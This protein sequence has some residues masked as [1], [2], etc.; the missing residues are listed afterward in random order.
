MKIFWS[1]QSDTSKTTGRFLVRDAIRAAI[2]KL[3]EV[4]DVEEPVDR[5]RLDS[6]HLDQDRQGLS[7]SPDL[8]DAIFKKIDAASIVIADITIVARSKGWRD[9]NNKLV[10]GRA[11]INPNVGIEVGYAIKAVGD[12]NILLVVN[13]HYGPTE[14]LP[15]DLRHKAI[16]LLYNLAPDAASAEIDKVKQELVSKLVPALRQYLKSSAAESDDIEIIKEPAITPPAFFFSEEK[17]LARIGV[18]EVDE[19]EFY[20]PTDRA[21]YLRLIPTQRRSSPIPPRGLSENVAGLGSLWLSYDAGLSKSNEQGHIVFRPRGSHGP[22]I[23][24][25]SQVFF[26]GE[27]WGI[28]RH[29]MRFDEQSNRLIIPSLPFEMT[30]FGSLYRYLTVAKNLGLQPPFIFEA[31]LAGCQNHWLARDY[32]LAYGPIRQDVINFEYTLRDVTDGTVHD[33]L[34]KFFE[35]VYDHT[36]HA[37]PDNDWGFPPNPPSE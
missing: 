18:P 32:G 2:K 21:L 13:T 31:G 7:G 12:S 10:K 22:E 4:E 30:Y 29:V 16:S 25:L 17:V 11:F 19:I 28:N 6:L 14:D 37:R 1:W 27:I 8:A 35:L 15:F 36:P 5:E 20:M 24:A 23:V 3:K 26:T 34:L 33:C 9:A